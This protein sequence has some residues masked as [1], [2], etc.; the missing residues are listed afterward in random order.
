MN[1]PGESWGHDPIMSR[2]SVFVGVP[3]WRGSF[4]AETLASIVPQEGV[5]LRVLVSIDGEDAESER[6][7]RPF[8]PDPR[9]SLV[10]QPDRLG[11]VEN[12]NAVLEAGRRSGADYVCIQ[13]HDDVMEPGYL[14]A[15]A[16]AAESNPDAA[17]TYCDIRCFGERQSVIAQSS[18]TGNAL[19]RQLTLL[20]EHF[21]AVA[22]RGLVRRSALCSIPLLSGNDI[23]D[24]AADAVWMSRLARAGEL[25]RVPEPLYRKRYHPGN[26]HT[27]WNEWDPRK[28]ALAWTRH[29]VDM[30]KEAASVCDNA[31]ALGLV[32]EAARARLLQTPSVGV[33]DGLVRGLTVR[34]RLWMRASFEI[35][36]LPFFR[37][38]N[39]VVS[40]R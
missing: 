21:A 27:Q 32:R 33:F 20:R 5:E 38:K 10:R 37:R 23:E 26:T 18:V 31:P 11:W 14:A 34:Q 9:I 3:V 16:R 8:L 1:A 7:C 19:R 36:T 35:A 2:C 6:A 25:I 15:L 13:P 40:M 28:K 30:F 4:V 39:R 12:S 22:Y 29:C 17:V 24:F